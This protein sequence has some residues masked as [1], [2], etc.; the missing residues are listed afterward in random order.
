M[1][2]VFIWEDIIIPLLRI[3]LTIAIWEII[4]CIIVEVIV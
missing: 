1:K 4:R 3:T 2:H